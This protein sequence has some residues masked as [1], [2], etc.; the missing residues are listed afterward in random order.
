M[1]ISESPIPT[2]EKRLAD[3]EVIVDML[4]NHA[5]DSRGR[6]VISLWDAEDACWASVRDAERK[7]KKGDTDA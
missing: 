5:H 6:P 7:Q 2:I 1:G 3:L 4:K